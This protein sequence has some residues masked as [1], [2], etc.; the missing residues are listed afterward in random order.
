MSTIIRLTNVTAKYSKKVALKD[1]SFSIS[2]GEFVGIIG[3]NGSGKTTMLKLILGL[4]KPS[5][6][7]IMV[8]GEKLSR[9]YTK[10]RKRIGYLSQIQQ[11]DT[12]FPI[13]VMDVV[14]FG[15]CTRIGFF[16]SPSRK[17]N[18]IVAQCLEK[19][20]MS[21]YQNTPFGHLSSGQQ[22]RVMI[23]RVLAQESEILFLDEPTTGIDLLAQGK[24]MDIIDELHA[25]GMTIIHVSH[26]INLFSQ[27]LQRVICLKQ[28]SLYKMGN[29]SEVLTT[30]VL[31]GLYDAPTVKI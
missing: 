16:K 20:G 6:G 28:S 27:S 13:N 14:M 12:N 4:I 2:T 21:E 3:P 31:K 19:V 8:F 22:Q 7:D 25:N 23:A 10:H 15:R 30:E 24:I 26:E 1:I 11:T 29:A 9:F 18:T 5:K 17:D